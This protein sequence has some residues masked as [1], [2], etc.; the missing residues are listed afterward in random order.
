MNQFFAE[1]AW[2]AIG[3]RDTGQPGTGHNLGGF[4]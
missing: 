3:H 2:S 4:F 1:D